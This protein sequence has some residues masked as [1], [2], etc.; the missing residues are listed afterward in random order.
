V[1]FARRDLVEPELLESG[2]QVASLLGLGRDAFADPSDGPPRDPQQV[3]DRGLERV[4]RKPRRGV[5]E[6]AR[7][8]G[9]EARPRHRRDDHPVAL[10]LNARSVRFQEADRRAE[11]KL[12]PPPPTL[13][14][15]IPR[16]SP[17][18]VRAAIPLAK[19]RADRHHDR[20]VLVELDLLD[21]HLLQPQQPRPRTDAYA[22]LA[23]AADRS[24][25]RFLTVTSRNRRSAAACAPPPAPVGA[26]ASRPRCPKARAGGAI[27]SA[28]PPQI[29]ATPREQQQPSRRCLTDRRPAALPRDRVH[30]THRN[31]SRALNSGREGRQAAPGRDGPLGLGA[32][33]RPPGYADLG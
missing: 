18:A 17:P 22:S 20:V 19:T 32:L 23:H 10:A 4:D 26:P 31:V 1:T 25:P 24:F 33:F 13:A 11:V 15:V 6:A 5:L 30:P 7:E 21:H 12:P 16:A 27:S 29:A 28:N 14:Q 2:E 9:V 8:T 3:A